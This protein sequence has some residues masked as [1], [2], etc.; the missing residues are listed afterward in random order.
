MEIDTL[1]YKNMHM[2]N[3]TTALSQISLVFIWKLVC[4]SSRKGRTYT[5]NYK[6]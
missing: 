1:S 4:L 6:M 2:K 5:K 3:M